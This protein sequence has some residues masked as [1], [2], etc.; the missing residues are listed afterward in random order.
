VRR[1]VAPECGR[2]SKIARIA[3]NIRF[4]IRFRLFARALG[5]P[6]FIADPH[7]ARRDHGDQPG[8]EA[9]PFM[10]ARLPERFVPG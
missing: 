6:E 10:A 1:G 5:G 2:Q 8:P 7:R 3:A 9:V 4:T